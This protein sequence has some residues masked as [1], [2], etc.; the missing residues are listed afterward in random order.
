MGKMTLSIV[1]KN[2]IQPSLEGCL[3]AGVPSSLNTLALRKGKGGPSASPDFL[4]PLPQVG[5][6]TGGMWCNSGH[7]DVQKIWEKCFLVTVQM[8][9]G[10]KYTLLLDVIG[11]LRV[12]RAVAAILQPQK[13]LSRQVQESRTARRKDF[14]FPILLSN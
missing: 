4:F 10:D 2:K 12:P 9:F 1:E 3:C 5:F 13:E 6:D 11:S 8:V 14:R 7:C